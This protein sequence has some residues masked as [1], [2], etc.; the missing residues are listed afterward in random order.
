[1]GKKNDTYGTQKP[2]NCTCGQ[3]EDCRGNYCQNNGWD[4][5]GCAYCGGGGKRTK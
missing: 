2:D 3:C 1:M 4:C 5:S